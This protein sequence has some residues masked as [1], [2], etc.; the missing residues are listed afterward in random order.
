MA[1]PEIQN[2]KPSFIERPED[3]VETPT[4]I[5]EGIQSTPSQPQPPQIQTQTG[6][7]AVTAV[8]APP[9][10][11]G[12]SITIPSDQGTLTQSAKG[13]TSDAS[14]WNAWFWLR[15]IKKALKRHINI[16]V[17]QTK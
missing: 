14:T 7:S 6:Q 1:T 8:P 17:G 10:A 11:A 9:A 16:L 13:Q 5:G 15:M 3:F 4:E 2:E 12:P